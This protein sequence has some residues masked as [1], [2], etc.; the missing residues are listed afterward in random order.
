MSEYAKMTAAE[1]LELIQSTNVFGNWPCGYPKREAAWYKDG[2][3][4]E[5]PE[6]AEMFQ[7]WAYDILRESGWKCYN[8]TANHR[9][10]GVTYVYP[11]I[12]D[13]SEVV[14]K[15]PTPLHALTEVIRQIHAQPAKV[16]ASKPDRTARII[17]V[18]RAEVL[19]WRDWHDRCGEEKECNCDD[20]PRLW[21]RNRAMR[22]T[23]YAGAL[24]A[25]EALAS[26]CRAVKGGGA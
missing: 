21:E 4:V 19:A 16:E 18:L 12:K 17:Q 23:N 1:L 2:Q 24:E 15:G 13:D 8:S 11:Y 3:Q 26:A 6:A 22:E 14:G 25:N 9:A 7:Q 10:S 5:V 20:K